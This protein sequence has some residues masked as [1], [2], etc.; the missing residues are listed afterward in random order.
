[1]CNEFATCN[2]TD[3]SYICVCDMG[4][5]GN[6]TEGFCEGKKKYL[7]S[8]SNGDGVMAV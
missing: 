4:Y 3:G 8:I 2:N 7:V 1:M 5:T 6:G